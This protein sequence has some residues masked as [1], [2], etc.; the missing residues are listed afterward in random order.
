MWPLIALTSERKMTLP[1]A[2][3]YF[4]SNLFTDYNAS[5][6]A[7]VLVMLPLLI[8]YFIFQKQF[9]ESITLTG[10]K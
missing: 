7:G 8:I 3:N 5:M 2:L 4:N 1:L 6:S 9:V 10:I